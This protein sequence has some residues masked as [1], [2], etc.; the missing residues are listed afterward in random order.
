MARGMPVLDGTLFGRSA[1]PIPSSAS[2]QTET[3]TES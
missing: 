3:C 1:G 2:G